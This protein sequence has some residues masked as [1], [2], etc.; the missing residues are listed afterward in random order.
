LAAPSVRTS[1]IQTSSMALGLSSVGT[2]FELSH[3]RF[4]SFK[5]AQRLCKVR[6]ERKL[7]FSYTEPQPI[8][9]EATV[10]QGERRG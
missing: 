6:A 8:F 5:Y 7:V 4:L 3:S 1:A 2:V 10:V 9:G